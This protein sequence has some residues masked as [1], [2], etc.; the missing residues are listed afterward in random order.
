MVQPLFTP[1]PLVFL[2]FHASATATPAAADTIVSTV[3]PTITGSFTITIGPFIA[4][5]IASTTIGSASVTVAAVGWYWDARSEGWFKESFASGDHNPV[6][7]M[8][9]DGDAASDRAILIGSDDGYIRKIDE[10]TATDDGTDIDAFVIIGPITSGQDVRS[11][12][13]SELQCLTDSGG[14]AIKW[15]ILTGDDPESALAT[16]ASTFTG[17]GTFTAGQSGVA[18][19]RR[20]GRYVYVKLGTTAATMRWALEKL[21]VRASKVTSDRGRKLS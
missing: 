12:V 9:F 13:V 19:P 7:V 17:D 2:G 1:T 4:S 10:S 6:A 15:E 16:E 20:R 3:A 5:T 18:N 11:V 8:T 21:R 14:N